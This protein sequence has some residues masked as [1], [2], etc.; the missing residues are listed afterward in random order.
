[1][2][3]TAKSPN[4]SNLATTCDSQCSEPER[5]ARRVGV[6]RD[7]RAEDQADDGRELH[8]DVERRARSV[9][10]GIAHGVASHGV[11]VSLGAL[12]ELGTKTSGRD[13]LLGV[14]PGAAGV[15]HGDG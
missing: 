10:Q 6:L 15:A 5:A 14:V 2:M 4:Y 8:H 1:M 9:L 11:L 13:V 7:G 3:L 12:P